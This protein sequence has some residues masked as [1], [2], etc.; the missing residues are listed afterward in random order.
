MISFVVELLAHARN[1]QY[2]RI[3][4]ETVL[5]LESTDSFGLRNED[6]CHSL[7]E[8]SARIMLSQF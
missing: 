2:R 8:A 6:E 7:A 3:S 1:D 4:T 5:F